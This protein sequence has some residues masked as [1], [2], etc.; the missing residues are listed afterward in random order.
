M[1]CGYPRGLQT[2][3]FDGG[4]S[5]GMQVPTQSDWQPEP[6]RGA[7]VA[8]SPESQSPRVH[9]YDL[10]LEDGSSDLFFDDIARFC[11][12]LMAGIEERAGS[13]L[14]GFSRYVQTEMSEAP[15]SR[16]EYALDLLTLGMALCIY[17]SRSKRTP[18]WVVALAR[19]LLWLRNHLGWAKP[20]VDR[21]R[22]FLFKAF[23]A[24]KPT[25]ESG[26]DP[27]PYEAPEGAQLLQ[28]LPSLI[29]WLRATGD[30]AQEATRVANWR[31]YLDTLEFWGA[32]RWLEV[33][34]ELFSSFELNAAGA[35]G[36]YTG[37][38]KKYL[39][40]EYSQGGCREDQIF[41]GRTQAEYHLNMVAAEVMNEGL[42]QA[43]ERA[44][45]K[46]VLVPTCMRGAQADTC[47]ARVNGVDM[48]CTACDPECAVNRITRRMRNLGTSVYLVPHTSGFS[49]WLDRW[50]R[51]PGVGVIAVACLLN[52]L[53]G[54][55][56]IRAR[57]IASQ[58]VPLDYPGCRKHWDREGIPTAVNEDRLVQIL[59]SI[60]R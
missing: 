7:E 40:T 49:R 57:R 60:P 24:V 31:N 1:L 36:V 2:C 39:A 29:R 48:T 54:G 23:L 30:L 18:R 25:T 22:G 3:A 21:V 52:I 37:G 14:D 43:F 41:C 34:G 10:R 26:I 59:A 50:Q 47:R 58:C 56:E 55:Y 42:K 12:Q 17:D 53:P 51:E 44:P 28:R 5:R 27:S 19:E 32:A 11:K 16:N 15:R 6:A 9:I 8:G 13:A 38:V 35:L 4:K 33:A 45:E 46:V 20:P